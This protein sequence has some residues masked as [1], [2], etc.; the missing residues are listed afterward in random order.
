MN[1]NQTALFKAAVAESILR[2]VRKPLSTDL[3]RFERSAQ[4][5]SCL[6]RGFKMYTII[7]VLEENMAVS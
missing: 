4:T 6:I 3:S 7:L 1:E 2:T 5:T